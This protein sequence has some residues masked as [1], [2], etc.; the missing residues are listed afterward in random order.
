MA[1]EMSSGQDEAASR[2]VALGAASW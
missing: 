2:T 1:G